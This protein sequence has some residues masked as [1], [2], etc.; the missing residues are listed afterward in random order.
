[1]LSKMQRLEMKADY[2]VPMRKLMTLLSF[3]AKSLDIVLNREFIR[4]IRR[5]SV[6]PGD[7]T[8]GMSTMFTQLMHSWLAV[9]L[10]K[11]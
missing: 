4:L 8:L 9:P 7:F 1:M 3:E 10:L 5:K 6:V 11:S 2:G